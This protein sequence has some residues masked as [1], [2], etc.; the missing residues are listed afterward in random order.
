MT[1]TGLL[2]PFTPLSEALPRLEAA[3][4]PVTGIVTGCVT[5]THLPDE[6]SLSTCAC[7]LAS[8]RRTLGTDSVTFGSGAHP[9]ARRARAAA[10][11]E[12]LER[13]S[14]AYLP[15]DRLQRA[16]A[17]QLGEGAVDPSRFAL[18]HS[19]Q[20]GTPGFPFVPFTAGTPT[21]F[22]E[23]TAL[24]DGSPAFLPAEL[25]YLSRPDLRAAPI[26]YAT[27]S[28][29]ACG[30]SFAE[31][32][33]GALF[34]LIERDAVM[35]A[36]KCR[37]TLP[38]LEWSGDNTL[39]TIDRTYFAATGG[40][41]S[42]IDASRFLEIPVAISV[43]RGH[44]GSGASLA[45]GAAAAAHVGDAW[46]KAVSE[47]FGVYRWLRHQARTGA[48]APDDPNNVESFDDHMLFY[49]SP[50]R[51]AA[52]TFFDGSAD[53]RP[54]REIG[55]VEGSAPRTQ[56]D[57]LVSKLARLDI[58]AYVVDVTSPDV[59]ELGLTVTRVIA[60]ELCALDV[61]HRA[62]FLGGERLTTAAYESG[63][64]ATPL[65]LV[66]VNPLPHPFP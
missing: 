15:V 44:P 43:L 47:S 28:G 16:T 46:L 62:R 18:F 4:S 54:T 40:R 59:R 9:D 29:L 38:L 34:E 17:T 48:G 64:R 13:Y 10:I 25:V 31:A 12:A 41:F 11:G 60:P 30:P 42:V 53:R 26:G 45:V 1:A 65:E 49:A 57:S 37:L 56:I 39:A 7:E 14:G 8:S 22:V 3:V 27:S 32:T 36:W 24:A 63:L 55:P 20:Y 58:A 2:E 21:T 52:A 35:L 5:S 19:S 61:S 23:G 50:E 6:S 51:A 33:L 66:D